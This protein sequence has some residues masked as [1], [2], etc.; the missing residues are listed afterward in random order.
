MKFF[1]GA[2]EVSSRR[3]TSP[4]PHTTTD[5]SIVST[6][7]SSMKRPGP[8][9][10]QGEKFAKRHR[11]EQNNGK[12]A[13]HI[14]WMA[15]FTESIASANTAKPTTATASPQDPCVFIHV[16]SSCMYYFH[17]HYQL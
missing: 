6:G 10:T 14:N 2:S 1:T 17:D 16:E 13:S 4:P 15:P 3:R 8:S 11:R 12:V 9:G 7:T 5:I